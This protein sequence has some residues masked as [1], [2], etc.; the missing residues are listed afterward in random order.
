MQKECCQNVAYPENVA[1]LR[2][3]TTGN[4]LAFNKTVLINKL[5]INIIETQ[6]DGDRMGVDERR[7]LE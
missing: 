6:K 1:L 2:N 5:A 7:V 4:L 3:R